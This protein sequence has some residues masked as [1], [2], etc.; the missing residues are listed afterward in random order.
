MAA[1]QFSVSNTVS[2][3]RRSAPPSIRPTVTLGQLS[4]PAPQSTKQEEAAPV[5][6][7]AVTVN[8]HQITKSDVDSRCDAVVKKQAQ[9][10]AVPPEQLAQLRARLG[11]EMLETLIDNRLLDEDVT[12]AQI[13]VT[14][15]DLK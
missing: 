3:N 15:T 5:E 8:G 7:V 14:N 12:K 10:R 11:P 1:L 13:K 9:G 2:T 6:R 4:P